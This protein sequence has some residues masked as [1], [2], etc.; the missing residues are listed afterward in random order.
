MY[1]SG[2]S[3]RC[4]FIFI[5][6][7]GYQKSRWRG[8]CTGKYLVHP[9][10]LESCNQTHHGY[11]V[12]CP[13]DPVGMTC[14]CNLDGWKLEGRSKA[15]TGMQGR[16]ASLF[17]T[18]SLSLERPRH[19]HFPPINYHDRKPLLLSIVFSCTNCYYTSIQ[20]LKSHHN[21]SIHYPLTGRIEPSNG[22]LV[23]LHAQRQGGPIRK[24]QATA[25][26]RSSSGRARGRRSR[27]GRRQGQAYVL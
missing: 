23:L 22:L 21:I 26:G 9:C 18:S 11:Y 19:V 4:I 14:Q 13:H 16:T 2:L 12:S 3:R 8:G 10:I 24:Q 6:E 5:Y 7:S 25:V 17:T 20:Y 27:Q 1:L 15:I